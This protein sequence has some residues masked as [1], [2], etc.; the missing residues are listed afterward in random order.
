MILGMIAVLVGSVLIVAGLLVAAVGLRFLSSERLPLVL[1]YGF[2]A[3]LWVTIGLSFV[4]GAFGGGGVSGWRLLGGIIAAVVMGIGGLAAG[5]YW[6]ADSS[7]D[8]SVAIRG[9]LDGQGE[10]V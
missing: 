9:P 8:P 1:G 5:D 2:V 4:L 7:N 3:S 6:E 10:S